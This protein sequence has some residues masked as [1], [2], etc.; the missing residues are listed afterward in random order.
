MINLFLKALYRRSSNDK[1]RGFT[2]HYINLSIEVDTLHNNS[3]ET[4]DSFSRRSRV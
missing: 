2:K 1:T 4:L 3:V